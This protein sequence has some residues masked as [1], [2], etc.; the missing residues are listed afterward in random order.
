MLYIFCDGY[1]MNFFRSGKEYL[2]DQEVKSFVRIKVSV[3][4]LYSRMVS[5][6]AFI[7]NIQ[8]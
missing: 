6:I 5:D 3:P 2:E 4:F 1:F 7:L 8:N